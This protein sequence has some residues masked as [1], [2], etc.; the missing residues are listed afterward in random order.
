[1]MMNFSFVSVV[2]SPLVYGFTN[3][4]E[5]CLLVAIWCSGSVIVV[6]DGR[7]RIDINLTINNNDDGGNTA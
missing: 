3:V 1:M 6:Q 5:E 2:V 4:G 7:T